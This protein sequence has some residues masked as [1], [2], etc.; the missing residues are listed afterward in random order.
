LFA[1]AAGDLFANSVHVQE[2]GAKP[3]GV[4]RKPLKSD[5]SYSGHL[6]RIP[7]TQDVLLSLYE[8]A[9]QI[10]SGNFPSA[11]S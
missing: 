2:T 11:D 5:K 7:L 6:H 1:L 10:V 9:L 4:P 3:I 8:Q